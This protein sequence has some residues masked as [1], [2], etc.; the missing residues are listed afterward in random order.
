MSKARRMLGGQRGSLPLALL[1][2]IIVAGVVVVLVARTA[3][4]QRQVQFDQSYHGA[5]PVADAGA[6]LAKF[7]LNNDLDL[8]LQEDD[9]TGTQTPPDEFKDGDRTIL[10]EDEIDGRTYEW[11]MTRRAGSWEVDSTSTDPRGRSDVQ[12]RV[13]VVLQDSPLVSIAAFA[14]IA[15][16][17][18]G[19]N[20]ADSYTSDPDVAAA[21]AWCTGNGFVGSNDQVTFEG[22]ASPGPCADYRP[23]GRTVDQVVL[24]DWKENPGENTTPELPGGDRCGQRTGQTVDPD[25]ENCK[26]MDHAVGEFPAPEL[27]PEEIKPDIPE[28]TDFIRDGL[29]ECESRLDEGES[30]SDFRSTLHAQDGL[31]PAGA[32]H[33]EMGDLGLGLEGHYYCYDNVYLDADT[34]IDESADIDDPVIMFVRND[35]SIAGGN[36]QN[37]EVSIG[38][39]DDGC[40]PGV[41]R[42]EAGRLWIFV[43]GGDVGIRA[44]SD[45][46]GVIWAPQSDCGGIG[47]GEG[48]GPSSQVDFYGSII[49]SSA[50][51]S[52]GWR[53]HF[54]DALGGA[55]DGLYVRTRWEELPVR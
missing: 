50:S 27:V 37:K 12:R 19:A 16:R 28:A 31:A 45:F 47:P 34:V 32:D 18:S 46:A 21:D 17:M 5:L 55:T 13:V 39:G 42:P 1:V 52:G 51:N 2:G 4:S 24:Y 9:S 49:C 33:P 30:L 3:A 15:F 22:V 36:N 48:G 26:E 41:S 53:F 10:M 6:E 25:H 8:L 40:T 38:C 43:Q 20:T 44:Q 54:D 7:Y 29:D 23:T 35:L 11:F 14:D